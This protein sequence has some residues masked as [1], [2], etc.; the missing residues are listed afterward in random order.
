MGILRF[1]E[2]PPFLIY[3]PIYAPAN[4]SIRALVLFLCLGVPALYAQ[5]LAPQQP[6]TS[7]DRRIQDVEQRAGPFEIAGQNYT[8][9]LR[10]KR[11]ANVSD[12][13]LSQTLAGV[14]ILDS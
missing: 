1:L 2:K 14:T 6:R 4:T 13:A 10:Q 11:L 7:Q 8:V 9:V 3:A 5:P 12:P